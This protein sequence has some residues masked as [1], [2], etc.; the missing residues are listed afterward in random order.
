[1]TA[2]PVA[3][4]YVCTS[5]TAGG[6]APDTFVTPF[7]AAFPHVKFVDPRHGGY[8]LATLTK[9]AWTTEM[10]VVDNMEDA[11]SGVTMI[12]TFAT[13]NGAPGADKA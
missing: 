11:Q 2:A 1:M 5:I 8:S 10:F 9:D 13:Q 6:T 7:A 3:T 4:E 12:A